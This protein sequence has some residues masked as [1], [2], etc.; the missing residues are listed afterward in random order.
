MSNLHLWLI[1]TFSTISLAAWLTYALPTAESSRPASTVFLPGD[2]THGHYQIEIK[3]GVCHNPGGDVREDSCLGCHADN[4]K[5]SHDTHPGSKF[6]DPQ[7]LPLLEKID[8]TKCITCHRE[9]VPGQT[10]THGLTVPADFCVNCHQDIAEDRPSHRTFEFDSCSSVGCHNYHDN[11]ALY[12]NFL[13]KHAGERNLLD[14]PRVPLRPSRTAGDSDES[15]TTPLTRTDVDAPSRFLEDQ[16]ILHEWESTAHAKAGVNCSRCHTTSHQPT[17]GVEETGDTADASSGHRGVWTSKVNLPVCREC[18]TEETDGFLA[19]MHGM[20]TAADLSPMS[21]ALARLPMNDDSFHRSLDCSSC[22]PGHRFDTRLASVEACLQCHDDQ[23][24]RKYTGSRHYQLWLAEI[25][26][27]A[28]AGSG[29]SCATCHMPRVEGSSVGLTID[30]V[31][32]IHNQNWNLEPVEKMIRSVCMNCHGLGFSLNA[33]ADPDL[34]DSCFEGMP[35][36]R[37]ETLDM[38]ESWFNS[39]RKEK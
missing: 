28:P 23:H 11:S 39:K 22:H 21:P 32:V 20:R 17:S 13:L 29:V 16:T 24:S 35:E 30:A 15:A 10:V 9:H 18:H 38:A 37:L 3:C 19:G 2:T 26:G 5:L 7:K 8:A 33:L 31:R 4:L 27:D 14:D 36:Y 1:W 12:E 34:K 6:R 25:Q